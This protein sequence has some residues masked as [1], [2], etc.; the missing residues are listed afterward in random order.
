[1]GN[2]P[3]LLDSGAR[4]AHGLFVVLWQMGIT[5]RLGKVDTANAMK[6]GKGSTAM[7]ARR[8]RPAMHSCPKAK[9]VSATSRGLL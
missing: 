1:M 3:V 9:V 4:I 2:A 6:A 8:I 5:D 7:Y